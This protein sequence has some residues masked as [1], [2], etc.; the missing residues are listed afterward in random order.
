MAGP[1]NGTAL[2]VNQTS[3]FSATFPWTRTVAA[4]PALSVHHLGLHGGRIAA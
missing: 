3:L 2:I 4:F 1:S